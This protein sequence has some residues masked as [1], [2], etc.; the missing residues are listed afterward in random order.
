MIRLLESEG[1]VAMLRLET[2]RLGSSGYATGREAITSAVRAGARAIVLDMAAATTLRASDIALLLELAA[3]SLPKARLS[4]MNVA[5]ALMSALKDRSVDQIIPVYATRER[6]FAAAEVKSAMLA[7]T[8]AVVLCAGEGRRIAPL[9]TLTPK[10]ML[11]IMGRPVLEHILRHLGSF[12]VRDVVLNPGHLGPQVLDHFGMGRATGQSLFYLN[13]G[14]TNEGRWSAAP[15]GSASTLARWAEDNNGLQTD[16]IVMCGDALVDVDLVAMMACH[17]AHDADITIAA[18]SV[19]ESDVHKYGIMV[20]GEAGRVLTFQEKPSREEARSKLA[21]TGIY[22]LS[23][24][25][26]GFLKERQGADIATDLLPAVLA[27]GGR[28]QIF[29]EPFKWID[30][31]CGRDYMAA[32]TAALEGRLPELSPKA[33]MIKSGVWA[34]QGAK[35]ARLG[36][37]KGPAYLGAGAVIERGATLRGPVVVG[38]D[39]VV[40]SGSYVRNSILCPATRAAEG[41]IV[42][43]AIATGNWAVMHAFADGSQQPRDPLP[44]VFPVGAGVDQHA[45]YTDVIDLDGADAIRTSRGLQ[46]AQAS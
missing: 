36:D 46:F 10:P 23:P 30:I 24:R 3:Q 33:E 7:N 16:T 42:D 12:G 20:H 8:P 41:S 21:N 15:L 11:D 17:R 38:K 29:D 45:L 18:Q 5:P 28:L 1:D 37:I 35:V 25:V 31:G 4:L 9:S 22:I 39:A 13:E 27:S 14:C 26:T 34:E 40:E 32:W 19:A 2:G 44:D 6:A 43:G